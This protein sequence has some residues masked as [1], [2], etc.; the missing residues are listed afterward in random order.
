MPEISSV[1][2]A[3]LLP[4]DLEQTQYFNRILVMSA[5]MGILDVLLDPSLNFTGLNCG[6]IALQFEVLDV[7][8]AHLRVVGLLS[9]QLRVDLDLAKGGQHVKFLFHFLLSVQHKSSH[10]QVAEVMRNC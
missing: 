8:V 4:F 10:V 1:S 9:H 2:F 3:F 5:S 7:D 6:D